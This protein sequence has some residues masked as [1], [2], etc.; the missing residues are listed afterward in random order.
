MS[1]RLKRRLHCVSA[2]LRLRIS[3]RCGELQKDNFDLSVDSQKK[4]A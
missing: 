2:R 3:A 4:G 1:V